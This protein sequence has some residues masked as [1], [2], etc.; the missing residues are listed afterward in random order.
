MKKIKS[1]LTKIVKKWE[2]KLKEQNSTMKNTRRNYLRIT[3]KSY[4]VV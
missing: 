2:Y 3:K 1:G 4:Q